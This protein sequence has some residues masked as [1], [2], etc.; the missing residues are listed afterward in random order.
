MCMRYLDW[1]LAIKKE[2]YINIVVPNSIVIHNEK[3]F[4]TFVQLLDVNVN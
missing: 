4:V 3:N 1:N 2:K